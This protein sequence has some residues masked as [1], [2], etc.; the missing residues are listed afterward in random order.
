MKGAAEDALAVVKSEVPFVVLGE[1]REEEFIT[2]ALIGSSV[3][4]AAGSREMVGM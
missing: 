3:F 2:E 1:G 4:V